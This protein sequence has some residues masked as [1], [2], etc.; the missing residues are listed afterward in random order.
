MQ[1]TETQLSLICATMASKQDVA[2]LKAAFA[3]LAAQ[4]PYL[5]V[6][7]DDVKAAFGRLRNCL[8]TCGA[9]LAVSHACMS[10]ILYL[11]LRASIAA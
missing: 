5:W 9:C 10:F 8:V 4:L 11:A 7:A 1:S 2:E 6:T 3:S